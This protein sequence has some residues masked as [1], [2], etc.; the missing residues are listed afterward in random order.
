MSIIGHEFMHNFN[1]NTNRKNE[2]R[3]DVKML[4]TG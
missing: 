4:V 3:T 2:A 1:M